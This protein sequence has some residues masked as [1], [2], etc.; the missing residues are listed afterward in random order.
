MRDA[1]P[2]A[3]TQDGS[4]RDG[5]S[6][7]GHRRP[8]WAHVRATVAGALHL[9]RPAFERA[10][11]DA[12]HAVT[13]ALGAAAPGHTPV[14]FWNFVPGLNDDVGP[15]VD[16]YMA[17]NVGRFQAC[18]EWLGGS[19]AFERALATA[20]A[21]GVDVPDLQVHC[22]AAIGGGSPVENPRQVSAYRYSSRYGPRPPC[23]ARAMRAVLHGGPVLLIGGTASIVGEQSLH[24]G[25]IGAQTTETLNNIEALVGRAVGGA[26]PLGHVREL[27]VYVRD[28]AHAGRVET[29]VRERCHAVGRVEFVR[30]QICR[31]ELLVE[32][33]GVAD[34][35]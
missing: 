15:G 32:I 19:D 9:P 11:R 10:A 14:R 31:K 12:Y 34:G 29:M 24:P 17:F 26:A 8:D 4:V 3:A 35:A 27:R 18:V 33:E 23:F 13:A 16:R 20:S 5:L 30:A 28:A 7:V 22:L 25:D 6:V 21:V 2:F 1:Q